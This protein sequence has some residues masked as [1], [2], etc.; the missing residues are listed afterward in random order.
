MMMRFP[1][2][3]EAAWNAEAARVQASRAMKAEQERDA[4]VAAVAR[5]SGELAERD[6]EIAEMRQ[7][8]AAM[9]EYIRE[10]QP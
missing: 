1:S 9:A 8:I 4:L 5:L 2:T 7:Q 6:R 3:P 10:V